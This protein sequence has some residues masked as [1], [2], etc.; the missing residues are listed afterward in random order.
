MSVCLSVTPSVRGADEQNK[1]VQSQDL[2]F[3]QLLC[4]DSYKIGQE[5]KKC[6]FQ[7]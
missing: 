6:R 1:E 4:D 7:G 5:T 2:V 3:L